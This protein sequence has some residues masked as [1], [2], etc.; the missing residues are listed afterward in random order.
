MRNL[1]AEV[2]VKR[3]APLPQG[4]DVLGSIPA[5][6]LPKCNHKMETKQP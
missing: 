2:G 1:G 3:F 5:N 6:Q 4:C